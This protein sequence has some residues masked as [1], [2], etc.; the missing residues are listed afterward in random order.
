[1]S[2][3]WWIHCGLCNKLQAN[4]E[5]QFYQL[6]CSDILCRSCMAET[7]RGTNCPICKT[8]VNFT[9]LGEYME[10]KERI[11]YHPSPVSF[12][13]IAAKTLTFQYKH[14]QNLVQAILSARKSSHRLDELEIKIQQKMVESQKEY[15][16]IRLYRRTLQVNMRKTEVSSGRSNTTGVEAKHPSGP[17]RFFQ[18]RLSTY[19]SCA[20][21]PYSSSLQPQR[22][23][24]VNSFNLVN[25]VKT[26]QANSSMDSG[27]GLTP[28]PKDSFAGRICRLC[29][30]TPKEIYSIKS[31]EIAQRRTSIAASLH[32]NYTPVKAPRRY[33][34]A[35]FNRVIAGEN[36]LQSG[37]FN[38]GATLSNSLFKTS[39]AKSS[40][41]SGIGLTPSSEDSFAGSIC[42]SS[43]STPK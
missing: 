39:Q 16:N 33:S 17:V 25:G 7:N 43:T 8:S 12:Y 3:Q 27:I 1:M 6:S 18:R 28:S 13:Q 32:T 14:R 26:S 35:S 41:N 5:S 11:L 15:E 22:R 30:S 20:I 29:S 40:T 24:S 36:A 31:S 23:F 21:Q 9:E 10:S 2:I 4:K 34:T 37:R 42:P 19:A 38:S